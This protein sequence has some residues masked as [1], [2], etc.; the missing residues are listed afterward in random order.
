MDTIPDA[1]AD[2]DASAPALCARCAE[3]FPLC[4]DVSFAGRRGG[5]AA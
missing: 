3:Y 1:C 2:C 4:Q 5:A